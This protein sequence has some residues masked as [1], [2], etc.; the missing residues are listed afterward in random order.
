MAECVSAPRAA[1]AHGGSA[2]TA[3]GLEREPRQYWPAVSPVLHWS[4]GR[5]RAARRVSGPRPAIP[6]RAVTTVEGLDSAR[7]P[8]VGSAMRPVR[9]FG[10]NWCR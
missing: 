2:E 4:R 8:S 6:M 10:M 1:H 3:R 5:P 9:P 7:P